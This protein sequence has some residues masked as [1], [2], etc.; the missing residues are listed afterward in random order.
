MS[1]VLSKLDSDA[2]KL[3][4]QTTSSLA[5]PFQEQDEVKVKVWIL[6]LSFQ[7]L[8]RGKIKIEQFFIFTYIM[9]YFTM[10]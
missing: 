3:S 6:Y 4:V 9:I 7:Y 2:S 5:V 10:I 1:F 8:L